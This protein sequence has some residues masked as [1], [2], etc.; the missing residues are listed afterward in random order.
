MVQWRGAQ[1]LAFLKP[2]YHEP[3]SLQASNAQHWEVAE[4]HIS[5]LRRDADDRYVRSFCQGFDLQVVKAGAAA[6][7]RG[8]ASCLMHVSAEDFPPETTGRRLTFSRRY[9]LLIASVCLGAMRLVVMCM[10]AS[11]HGFVVC[12]SVRFSV[13]L[14]MQ[15]CH[16]ICWNWV[17][18]CTVSSMF[19]S[20]AILAQARHR[21]L[22]RSPLP[23]PGARRQQR[24]R[25]VCVNASPGSPGDL[26]ASP[27]SRCSSAAGRNG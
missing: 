18:V 22:R 14:P 24:S 11:L 12:L 4:L 23:S 27:A 9:V 6:L 10:S 7:A 13:G 3:V 25:A 2:W 8:V 16:C 5:G 15:C 17:C 21:V 19:V 26:V 20:V 1:T